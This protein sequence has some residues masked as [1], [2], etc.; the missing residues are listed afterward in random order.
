MENQCV[1][2]V[3]YRPSFSALS[4]RYHALFSMFLSKN[5]LP[6]NVQLMLL[7]YKQ[8]YMK[9]KT[10]HT[11]TKLRSRLEHTSKERLTH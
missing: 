7:L 4:Q 5:Q 9:P 6:T 3:K 1:Q 2:K 11:F 10:Y 8:V